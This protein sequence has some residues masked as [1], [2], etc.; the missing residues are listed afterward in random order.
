MHIDERIN[1][2]QPGQ[3]FELSRGNGIVETVEP[4]GDGKRIRF[5]RQTK[6]GFQVFRD[7]EFAR[8]EVGADA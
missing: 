5:V 1:R 3:G 4:S 2:L 7:V 6:D 8:I